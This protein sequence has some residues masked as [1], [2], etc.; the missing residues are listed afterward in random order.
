MAH[1][2]IVAHLSLGV[3]SD[4]PAHRLI[5]LASHS[6]HTADVAV[7]L[8][9]TDASADV[10]LVSEV[11]VGFPFEPVDPHPSGLLASRG[12]GGELL[13][14]SAFGL[15]ALVTEH[16][17]RD[18][19]YSRVSGFVCMLMT[20]SAFE[21]RA[22][23]FRHMLPVIVLDRLDGRF[24]LAE[25][26][27]QNKARNYYHGYEQYQDFCQSL[28]LFIACNRAGSRFPTGFVY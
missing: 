26:I 10:R 6:L 16:A 12:E 8:L 23:F 11:C 24:R 1:I 21:S 17:G 5:N 13:H 4:A 28:H 7:T 19:R 14:L 9:A 25:N 27:E 2:A 20:E 15:Y 22:V 18:I 3:A